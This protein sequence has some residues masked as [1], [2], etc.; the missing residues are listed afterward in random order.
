MHS[1]FL[2][3][4]KIMKWSRRILALVQHRKPGRDTTVRLVQSGRPLRYPGRRLH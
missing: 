3:I 2:F 1:G 4:H